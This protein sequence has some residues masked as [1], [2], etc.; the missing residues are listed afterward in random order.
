M[1]GINLLLVEDEEKLRKLVKAYLVKE[2]VHVLEAADGLEAIKIWEE[3][4]IDFAILDIMLPKYDGWTLCKKVREESNIPIIML[5]ARSEET[6]KLFGF[7]LGADDYMTK[8]FSPKELVARVK[9]L[10]K[11]SNQAISEDIIEIEELK[12]DKKSHQ[13]VLKGDILE[14]SPKEYDLLLYFLHNK[15]QA[16]TREMILNGVWGYDYYGDLRTVD[17]HVKRLRQKLRDYGE[18]VKTIRGTGYRFEVKA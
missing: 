9:A 4:K 12:V 10:L 5:T 17:T 3:N 6:D 8:P 15:N 18:F 2:G 11:R 7:E 14:L 13:V 1:V 16:L